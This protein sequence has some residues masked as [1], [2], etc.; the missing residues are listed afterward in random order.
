MGDLKY[1]PGAQ[2]SGL[3][4][5]DLGTLTIDRTQNHRNEGDGPKEDLTGEE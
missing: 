2:G 1:H 5:T 4:R 3:I